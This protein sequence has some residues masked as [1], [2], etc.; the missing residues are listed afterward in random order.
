MA[1]KEQ[2]LQNSKKVNRKYCKVL[3]DANRGALLENRFQHIEH[4]LK[5]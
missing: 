2:S 5:S 1:R 3:R 4:S